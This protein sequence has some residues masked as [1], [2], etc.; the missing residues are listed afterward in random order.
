[1][2][3]LCLSV[4]VWQV[5]EGLWSWM[6]TLFV[7]SGLSGS[8]TTSRSMSDLR[9]PVGSVMS[10]EWPRRRLLHHLTASPS[11]ILLLSFNPWGLCI[12][13]FLSPS[14]IIQ[15]PWSL[16]LQGIPAV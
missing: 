14:P 8:L 15:T 7:E 3:G 4:G 10:S 1:M 11:Q 16:V 9:S 2:R 5:R 12:P 13:A 6:V